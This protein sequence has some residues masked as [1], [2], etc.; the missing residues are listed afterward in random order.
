MQHGLTSGG[1]SRILAQY[2]ANKVSDLTTEQLGR[3]LLNP[4]LAALMTTTPPWGMPLSENAWRA[5]SAQQAPKPAPAP[6]PTPE[7]GPPNPPGPMWTPPTIYD[8]RVDRHRIATQEDV[9]RL[10]RENEEL[11]R[12]YSVVGRSIDEA[13]RM[14]A[15]DPP[16]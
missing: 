1:L 13:R 11:R 8:I 6:A 12:V 5:Y 10:V 3:F 9:D 4:R 7:P 15:M 16:K 14:L 2:N